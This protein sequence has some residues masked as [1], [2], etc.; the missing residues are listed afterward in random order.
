MNRPRAL[1]IAVA[2]LCAACSAPVQYR[3]PK[4]RVVLTCDDRA[5][6][7]ISWNAGLITAHRYAAAS[8]AAERAARASLGCPDFADR[9]RGANALIVAAELAHQAKQPAR[10]AQLLG[11]GYAIMNALH[12]PKHSSELTSTLIAQKLDT[13]R[14]DMAG[15]W[16]YW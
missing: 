16:A 1:L 14:Q 15:R 7:I 3:A 2:L 5:T 11:E 13:A 4:E 12:L 10:A 9:W 6:R 8:A